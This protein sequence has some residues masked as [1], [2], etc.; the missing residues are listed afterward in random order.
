MRGKHFVELTT[1]KVEDDF[2]EE[3]DDEEEEVETLFF[4]IA[5]DPTR[6][7]RSKW[8]IRAFVIVVVIA[9]AI[10]ITVV[11]LRV[12]RSKE[13]HLSKVVPSKGCYTKISADGDLKNGRF[14]SSFEITLSALN[15]SFVL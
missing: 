13:R 11:V 1:L 6:E 4:G 15:R 7:R 3:N 2:E 12:P 10:T 14:N 9:I 5:K 8:I